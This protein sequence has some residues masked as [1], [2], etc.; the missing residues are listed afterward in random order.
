MYLETWALFNYRKPQPRTDQVRRPHQTLF[1][2]L[3]LTAYDKL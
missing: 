1:G 2:L 3:Y